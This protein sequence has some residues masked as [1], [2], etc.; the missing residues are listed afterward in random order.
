MALLI[1]TYKFGFKL[2][3]GGGEYKKMCLFTK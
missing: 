3:E 2:N 1:M